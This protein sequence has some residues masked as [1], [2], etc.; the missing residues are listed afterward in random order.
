MP[1]KSDWNCVLSYVVTFCQ[2]EPKARH[3]VKVTMYDL[4]FSYVA[5]FID[6]SI[7]CQGG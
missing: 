7:Q 1:R 5:L 2:I 4:H 6:I 3:K